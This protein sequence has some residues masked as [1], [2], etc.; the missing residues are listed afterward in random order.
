MADSPLCPPSP[1]PLPRF[2]RIMTVVD[3]APPL[4]GKAEPRLCTPSL[5]ELTRE[6]SYGFE[7]ID[8]AREIGHPLLPWQKTAVVRGGELLPDGRPRFRI[9]V[10]LVSRQ[11]GKTEL[12]VVLSAFWQ[13]RQKVPLILGTST[14]L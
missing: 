11:N 3:L 6:T 5:R 12:P 14:Q 13:F 9:V 4:L 8:F 7:V 2:G 1:S 10:L